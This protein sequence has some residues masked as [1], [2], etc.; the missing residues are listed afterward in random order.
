MV[1]IPFSDSI[2][3]TAII[4]V[5]HAHNLDIKSVPVNRVMQNSV[6][7]SSRF[8]VGHHIGD[9]IGCTYHNL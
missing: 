4:L 2:T 5:A 3:A 6:F 8:Y 9:R 7:P 1:L